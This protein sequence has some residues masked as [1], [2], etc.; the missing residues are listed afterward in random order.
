MEKEIAIQICV[1]LDK[2]LP[3]KYASSFLETLEGKIIEIL[4]R[5]LSHLLASRDKEIAEAE[6][7]V[8][9][10]W[11]YQKGNDHDNRIREGRDKEI[12][13]GVEGMQKEDR[14]RKLSE[15]M[16]AADAIGIAHLNE[17]YNQALSDFKQHILASKK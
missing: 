13:E 3:N 5:H 7:R 1:M 12:L 6:K 16:K 8:N 9:D 11:M 10:S 4:Q 2:T 17:S 14:W 15:T